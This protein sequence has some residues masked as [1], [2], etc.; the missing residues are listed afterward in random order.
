[1]SSRERS[2]CCRISQSLTLRQLQGCSVSAKAP[3]GRRERRSQP[4]ER[5]L[6]AAAP[7]A[8]ECG[9]ARPMLASRLAMHATKYSIGRGAVRTASAGKVGSAQETVKACPFIGF[10]L[11]RFCPGALGCQRWSDGPQCFRAEGPCLMAAF[12]NTVGVLD[13]TGLRR[14][15]LYSQDE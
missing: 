14:C 5:G 7:G 13:H 2:P 12:R 11:E 9:Q 6:V 10:G 8:Q 3:G 4:F 1:M 15:R